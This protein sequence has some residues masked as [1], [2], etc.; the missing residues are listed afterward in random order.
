MKAWR[1]TREPFRALDGRGGEVAD[2]RWHRRGQRVVYA[3]A[4]PSL[5]VLEVLVNLDLPLEL[6]PDDFVLMKINIPD[7]IG[8]KQVGVGDLPPG[9][10]TPEGLPAR[11][12]SARWI[13][14]EESAVMLVPSAI[15]PEENNVLI[16]PRHSGAAKIFEDSYRPF[17]FDPRLFR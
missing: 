16:N 12:F 14:E 10:D 13:G 1:L 5:T 8:I 15:V 9:W 3:A 4:S 2:G 6:L 17:E 7:E 11:E